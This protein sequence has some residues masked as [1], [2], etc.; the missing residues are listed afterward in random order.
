MMA[1]ELG[2]DERRRE[3]LSLLGGVAATWPLAAR[4]QQP[5]KVHRIGVLW[6]AGSENEEAVYLG[7]LRRGFR[8]I[9]HVEGKTFILENRFPDEQPERMLTM[10]K[11]LAALRVDVLVAVTALSALAAPASRS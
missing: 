8:D 7:A 3:F 9:G 1:S 2:A 4:A 5:N 6:H 11:E 10:A